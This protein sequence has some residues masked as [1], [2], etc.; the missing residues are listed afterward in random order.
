MSYAIV[1]VIAMPD[2]V[3]NTLNS[4]KQIFPTPSSQSFTESIGVV[5]AGVLDDNDYYRFDLKRSSSV[6]ISLTNLGAN[7]NVQLLDGTGAPITTTDGVTLTSVNDSTLPESLNAILAAGTYYVRVSPGAAIGTPPTTPSTNYTLNI[8]ANENTT[9]DIL[10]RNVNGANSLWL[11][12]GSTILGGAILPPVSDPAWQIQG[13][14]DFNQDGKTDIVW[15]HYVSGTNTVWFMNGNLILS[16]S[17]LPAVSNLTWQ[18]Q[19][20]GD[21]NQ[22]GKPDLVWRNTPTGI[23]T[24][25]FMNE[26]SF[27]SGADLPAVPNLTW[28]IRG[29][30]DFNQD[31]SP[32]LLW[33]NTVTGDNTIWFMNGT[34]FVSAASLPPADLRW[35]IQGVGDFNKDGKPDLLWRSTAT[36]DTTFWLLDGTTFIGG[37]FIGTVDLSWQSA[38]SSLR[39]QA[40]VLP[41][42]AGNSASAAFQI[43]ALTGNGVY[44]DQ[45]GGITGTT[46]DSDDY[47]QFILGSQT[48]LD[49]ALSGP[50]S[51]S[52]TG[53]LDV[54]VLNA[55]GGVVASSANP[56]SANESL[57]KLLDPGVYYLRVQPVSGDSFY[58]LSLKVNNLPFVAT[59]NSLTLNEE[60]TQTIGSSLLTI[61]DEN[62]TPDRL[63]Y[64]VVST[65]ASG[66]LLRSGSALVLG[67][68]F[69]QADINNNLISYRH[70]GTETLSDRFVFSVQDSQNGTLPLSPP[71]GGTSNRTFSISVIPIND[72]P[73]LV[74]NNPLSATEGAAQLITNTFLLATDVEQPAAQLAY[75]LGILPT[76]GTLIRNGTTLSVGNSFTQADL[77]P[78]SQQL[79]YV[80]DGSE[81]TTD[82]FVFTLTDGAGGTALPVPSTFNITVQAVNDPPGLV[83]NKG[84]AISQGQ[85]AALGT[86]LLNATD[87]EAPPLSLGGASQITYTILNVADRPL[88]GTLFLNS[89]QSDIFTQGDINNGRVEYSHNNSFSNSDLFT[90]RLF[91]G[92]ALSGPFTFNIGVDV[93]SR[94]PVLVTNNPLVATEGASAILSNT[95]LQVTDPDSPTPALI[96]TLGS[97]PSNGILRR[98]GAALTTGQTFSQQDI[99]QNLLSYEQNGSETTSD[100]FTFSVSDNSGNQISNQMFSIAVTPTNDLP[101]LVT[102]RSL[103]LSE[104]ALADI[105]SSLLF[106]TDPD[107]LDTEISYVVAGPTASG[108]LLRAG[109]ATTFFTQA[110]INNGLI[111]YQHNGS[112]A[113]SDR[114]TFTITDLSGVASTP[115]T[116]NIA[117]TPVNDQPGLSLNMGL[118]V[119]E[120][121]ASI[122]IDSARLLV[123]DDDG[124]GPITY[125]L[126][127]VPANGTL[128]RN[129]ILLSSGQTFTQAD[130]NGGLITYSHD[131]SETTSDGFTFTVSDRSTGSIGTTSFSIAVQ[132]VNDLPVL[133]TQGTGTLSEG[134]LLTFNNSL[135]L[136]T[137][138]DAPSTANLLYTIGTRPSQ[139]NLLLGATTLVNG[140]SFT[141]ADILGSQLRYQHSGN[142]TV[143]DNFTF[144][145]GD[146]IASLATVNTFNLNIT[147]VNDNPGLQT[148]QGLD[149]S[150]GESRTIT[151]TLLNVTD[152]DGP[153]PLTYTVS[154][155]PVN[156]SLIRDGVTLGSG[157]TFTQVDIDNGLITYLHNGGETTSDRFIFSVS[158]GSTG[159]IGATTFSINVTPVN[160]LPVLVTNLGAT[161]S[162]DGLL[163]FGNSLLLITD[164]DAATAADLRYTIAESP[165]NGNLVLG[166]VTLFAGN[167]FTQADVSSGSLRYRHN[168]SET[169]SDRFTFNIGDGITSL[170]A[171]NTFN[172]GITPVNDN[173]GIQTNLVLQP[174]TEGNTAILS[175]TFLTVTD[176]DGPGPL[177]Y[178]LG[179]APLN[180]TL[181]KDGFTL[182][183]GQTFTQPDLDANLISYQHNGSE[184]TSDRFTFTVS[185]G[186]TGNLGTTTF[187]IAVTPAN[188]SPSLTAPTTITLEEDG[189][190]SLIGGDLIS[191]TDPDTALLDV[192]LTVGNGTLE[193]GGAPLTNLVFSSQTPSAINTALTNLIYRPNLN[194]NGPDAIVITANDGSGPITRT[195]DISVTPVNDAPTLTVPGVQTVNEDT[196][197]ALSIPNTTDVDSGGSPVQVQMS[198]PNGSLTLGVTGGLSFVGGTANGGS[199]LTFTGTI[200]S[201]RTAL[202]NFT[203]RG[204][205]NFNGADTITVTLTDQGATGAGGA[206]SLTRTIPVTVTAVND[207][208][209]FTG[210]PD[211]T[212]LEDAGAITIANWAT[213]I[214][215]GAAN[216]SQPLNFSVTP[217]NAGLFSVAPSVNSSNGNLTFTLTPNAFGSSGVVVTLSDGQSVNGLSTPYTFSVN[218]LP[219]NDQPT[220]TRIAGVT[221][222]EDA[223]AQ[224]ILW[225]TNISRGPTSPPL[226]DESSQTIAFQVLSNSN[227]GLFSVQ[228]GIT[229]A[230]TLT[231]TPAANA[232]GVAILSA[233]LRD[234]GGVDNGG[235]DT[236]ITQFFTIAVT[237]VNDAPGLI[238]PVSSLT[239]N[240]D[241]AIAVSGI[242]FTDVDAGSG[243]MEVRVTALGTG[244]TGTAGT[245][246]FAPTP[247]V[248]YSTSNVATDVQFTGNIVDLNA[249]LSNFI[250]TGAKDVNGIDRLVIRVDDRGSTGG[251]ARTDFQTLTMNLNAV[252]DKPVMSLSGATLRS[253]AED[254]QL[255]VTGFSVTDVDA[256]ASNVNVTLTAQ[257]GTLTVNPAGLTSSGVGTNT[258]TLSGTLAALNTALA[259]LRYQGVSNYNGTDTILATVDDLGFSGSGGSLTDSKLLSL[260]VTPV[261]DLP[262]LT[263]PTTAISVNEDTDLPFTV[264]NAISL[265]D[266]DSG[267]TPIRMTLS[268]TNGTLTLTP[269]GLT[270]ISGSNGTST[271]VYEGTVNDLQAALSTL[272][273]RGKQDY[274]GSDGLTVTVNDKGATGA[275]SGIDVTRSV[276]INVQSVNDAPVL[277]SNAI[278]TLNEAASTIIG[279]GLLRTTDVDN[280]PA[281]N[282]VYTL[283]SG[284]NHGNL[285]L[286]LGGGSTTL[287][288]NN[289]FTQADVNSNF[290]RYFHDSGETTADSFSF[291]VSDGSLGAS[292][293]P[294]T[295]NL[296]INPIN[297][298]PILIPNPP[299]ALT[300][301]EAQSAVLTSVLLSVTDPDNT[302]AQIRYT[303]TGLPSSGTVRLNSNNL[304]TGQSFSQADVN[305]GR[306]SYRHNGSETLSDTFLFTVND[307]SGGSITSTGFNVVVQPVND[308]PVVLS[309]GPLTLNEGGSTTVSRSVLL[310]TDAENQPISYTLL[311]SPLYGSLSLGG[312]SIGANAIFTQQQ[313]DSGALTYRHNGSETTS[314]VFTF[315]VSDSDPLTAPQNKIFNIAINPVND[316][317]VLT[318]PN[319]TLELDGTFLGETEISNGLLLTTDVDNS[320]T[321]LVYTLNQAPTSG[322]LVINEPGN[323]RVILAGQTFTQADID[324]GWLRYNLTTTGQSSDSLQISVSDGGLGA[325]FSPTFLNILFTYS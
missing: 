12:D 177:T 234:S 270:T 164:N 102:N 144:T 284:V 276:S 318:T 121:D 58:E 10:W 44:Q 41:D 196:D 253:V 34:S 304:T 255:A 104:G 119:T 232:N 74:S 83:T 13:T 142:E 46:T 214:S 277:L 221:V 226:A 202:N 75:T 242:S 50:G 91:D 54:F 218:A 308:A 154:N 25:W 145:I 113:V 275:T 49:L 295:F 26:V 238:L 156:G 250:Y 161:V 14:G 311:A 114:F 70:D 262:L 207:A 254:T 217:L 296:K 11:M 122:K 136:I 317:P 210:G 246:T 118:A 31:A 123:T 309:T 125:T 126:G 96:Y 103:A 169:T 153:G 261:N 201:V 324:N 195:I 291:N 183:A 61:G 199:T 29:V 251:A 16:G 38:V 166:A 131:G 231:Y 273:Y 197:L 288:V 240:E 194:Y 229:P 116:F 19:G 185:D 187:S 94:V 71:I 128:R 36:G 170:A 263:L 173:P 212:F 267:A 216:E 101:G 281:G 87:A 230:G 211:Q 111:Q 21:F 27:L 20:V 86:T 100:S 23:N 139:G 68:T 188:D 319:P 258:V 140:N 322:Q 171:V 132:A 24:V 22:D 2:T 280:P 315:R 76:H 158:D 274:N 106:T 325:A 53:N 78:L 167:S 193:T 57:S 56:G 88:N 303:L 133:V 241:E 55:S 252:N 186:S 236:S 243:T 289:T 147:P 278:V 77:D 175:N 269:T 227:P 3:G 15:R 190:R 72:P 179:L 4:A 168:G 9:T 314:D 65:P 237:A 67:S 206:Q 298:V 191:V 160:D 117:V 47:Y 120:G 89:V 98:L 205:N 244:T 228:P 37:G 138:N 5:D 124:P 235:V 143:S 51:T 35:Q 220:F 33:R 310:T 181:L 184:T 95:F 265:T 180:G 92:Q 107:N 272:V 287:G 320:T 129:G 213:N 30:G 224:S 266:I 48:Q 189:N 182:A 130:I 105:T 109:T 32:D 165:T 293:N 260:N 7:A 292:A 302:A 294:A 40:P 90:F 172:L 239:T 192:S 45:V 307:G 52:L 203:Y 8:S 174:F 312:V 299:G 215:T 149:L 301:T 222:T 209:T 115:R 43:G 112:E 97:A 155:V 64:S 150:E 80:H 127:T 141:Q 257:N 1:G 18:I 159:S 134:G 99:D 79:Q 282:L 39:F 264:A 6:A 59:L 66:N 42:V 285:V 198:A 84:L 233:N 152:P 110:D 69:T 279:N 146:G 305:A 219:V 17:Y 200:N 63:T 163:T 245:L 157:Q 85:R 283:L 259:S 62:D 223:P 176:P 108:S 204:A 148:K 249:A 271:A 73:R 135:L 290:L 81:T 286:V 268:V 300:V 313:I 93:V 225:A 297:D 82:S 321:Q 247:G 316:Q 323:R 137:D 256:G 28:Q 162:E 60:G 306:V 151:N 208:P 248:N 178:T